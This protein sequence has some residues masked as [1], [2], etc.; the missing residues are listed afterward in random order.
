METKEEKKAVAGLEIVSSE[1]F[2]IPADDQKEYFLQEAFLMDSEACSINRSEREML[3]LLARLLK[4]ETSVLSSINSF[5]YNSA[6]ST[7]QLIIGNYMIQDSINIAERQRVNRAIT[8]LMQLLVGLATQKVIISKL[9]NF[10][11]KQQ[12]MLS[13]VIKNVVDEG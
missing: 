9:Q 12:G 8:P 11:D 7:L 13:H 5:E 6:I 2:A 10:C 4:K 1:K 3:G